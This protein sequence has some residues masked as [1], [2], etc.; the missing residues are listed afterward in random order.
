MPE[1]TV[2]NAHFLGGGMTVASNGLVNERISEN[3]KQIA[4]WQY[5]RMDG[6]LQA[7]ADDDRA[8]LYDRVG[9]G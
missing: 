9:V 8:T 7:V 5:N 2:H 4:G 6:L 3:N 1:Q